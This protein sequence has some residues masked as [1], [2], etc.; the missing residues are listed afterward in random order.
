MVEMEN[1][2]EN[3]TVQNSKRQDE[4]RKCNAGPVR[5]CYR[6]K[7]R[8]RDETQRGNEEDGGMMANVQRVWLEQT[9]NRQRETR[10]MVK[11]STNEWDQ[12]MNENTHTREGIENWHRNPATRKA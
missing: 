5:W 8:V 1:V 12:L 2:G 9:R 6:K 3:I 11:Q 10:V 4:Q 7:V